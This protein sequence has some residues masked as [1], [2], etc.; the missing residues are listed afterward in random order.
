MPAALAILAVAV[1][2]VAS[3]TRRSRQILL[4]VGADPL[5]HRK[6]LAVTSAL[7]ALIAAVLAIPAGL[8]PMVALWASQP[9]GPSRLPL[10]IPWA[11]IGIVVF[12]V[13]LVAALVSGVVARAPKLG[14]LLRPAT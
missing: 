4:A 6:L 1:A 7:L 3:E 14:S 10:V 13:P 11:T 5:S 2:L 12:L 8:L 9:V